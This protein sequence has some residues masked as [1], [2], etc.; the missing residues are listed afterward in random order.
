M[1][2]DSP[3]TKSAQSKLLESPTEP[4]QLKMG[5]LLTSFLLPTLFGKTLILYFGLNYSEHPGEGYGVGLALS[6]LFTLTMLGRFVWRFRHY[7][8]R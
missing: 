8:D 3:E 6:I 7:K 1:S 4:R 2:S 5:D